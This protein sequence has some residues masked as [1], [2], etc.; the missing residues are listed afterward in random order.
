MM[1]YDLGGYRPAGIPLAPRLG[2]VTPLKAA[3][4]VS[5]V[6]ATALGVGTAYVGFR[7]GERDKGTRKVL[8]YTVAVFGALVTISGVAGILGSFVS[9]ILSGERKAA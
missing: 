8:G 1:R 5:S 6:L 7:S 9:P 4:S 3:L 2:Q